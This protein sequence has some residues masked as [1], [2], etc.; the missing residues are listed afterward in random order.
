MAA[1]RIVAQFL[2]MLGMLNVAACNTTTTVGDTTQPLMPVGYGLVATA[3]VFQN[4]PEM[5]LGKF[6]TMDHVPGFLF[7]FEALDPGRET[8]T[9]FGKRGSA[10]HIPKAAR[11]GTGEPDWV[12]M[13]TPVKPGKYRETYASLNTGN[14]ANVYIDFKD[15]PAFEVVAG[16]V[17]YVGAMFVTTSARYARNDGAFKASAMA[18]QVRDEFARDLTE[19]KA[20]DARLVP[21]VIKDGLK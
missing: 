16:E 20:M 3:V 15:L 4:P 14:S 21:M 17:T 10:M 5:P 18:V 9:V 2:L 19:L 13:L 6:Y 7:S 1:R 11:S 8:F 12:M